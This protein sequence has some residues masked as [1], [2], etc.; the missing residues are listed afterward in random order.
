MAN[1]Q[2][3]QNEARQFGQQADIGDLRRRVS[4]L[5]AQVQALN[6]TVQELTEKLER[7][8]GEPQE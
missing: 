3:M 1:W 4:Q 5:E 6:A 2:D 8:S 7:L